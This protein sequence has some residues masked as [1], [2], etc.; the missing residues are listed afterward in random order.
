MAILRDFINS[1]Q[2]LLEKLYDNV[3]SYDIY[4]HFFQEANCIEEELTINQGI[5]YLSP[6]RHDE[7]PTVSLFTAKKTKDIL[8]TDFALGTTGD[9]LK[10]VKMYAKHNGIYLESLFDTISFINMQMELNLFT[11]N[12]TKVKVENRQLPERQE[13]PLL[14]KSRPFTSRDIK[15]WGQFNITTELLDEH[16]IRSVQYMLNENNEV[17]YEFAKNKLAYAL[18]V[19][20]KVKIYCPESVDF[21]WRSNVPGNQWEYYQGINNLKYKNTLLITKSYKDLLTFKA[22][23]DG[24]EFDVI[25]PQSETVTLVPEFVD[26]IKKRYNRIIVVMDYDAAGVRAANKLKKLYGFESRFVS[27]ERVSINGKLKCLYKDISDFALLKGITA[28]KIRVR[29]I[30]S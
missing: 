24:K 30:V 19:N 27:T 14:F 1:K 6:F 22:L 17:T 16:D 21:K 8:F 20:D 2:T 15:Y 5:L 11:S 26:Y 12:P 10:F 18:V 3:D 9:V 23:A 13:I 28:G 25:A 4:N 7:K 29:E